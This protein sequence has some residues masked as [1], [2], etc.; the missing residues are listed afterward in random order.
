M[1]INK[2]HSNIAIIDFIQRDCIDNGHGRKKWWANKLD[3]SQMTLSHWLV[4]R[5]TPNASHWNTLFMVSEELQATNE[6][7]MWS[8]WLW[9]NY[10]DNIGIEPII[11]KQ[12]AKNLMKA[13]GLQSRVL[14]LLS[15]FFAKYEP[16]PFEQSEFFNA[17]HWRN[18]M[19]W[20]YESAGLQ[21]NL[22]PI[23]L[24]KPEALLDI[25]NLDPSDS[26]IARF[27]LEGQQTELGRKW[28]LFDCSMAAL[29]EKLDWRH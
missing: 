6:R 5:R 3:V 14:A 7:D 10:Y 22:A 29:K 27:Y 4:G 9:Q 24:N 8:N 13:E 12:V 19:G 15:W 21:S 2:Q 18:K 20:L 28:Q 26:D 1:R 17:N 25:P 11:L 16:P 23:R